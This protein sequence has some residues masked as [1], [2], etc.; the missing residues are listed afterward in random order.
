MGGRAHNPDRAV[1][2]R[3]T[4]SP[5]Q[6]STHGHAYS[7]EAIRLVAHHL[8][9]AT[10]GH[11][12]LTGDLVDG[13]LPLR[14]TPPPARRPAGRR[15]L[16]WPR[17]RVMVSAMVT[18]HR[19]TAALALALGLALVAPMGADAAR[20][21]DPTPGASGVGD[22]FFPHGG[23]G[24]YDVASYQLDL[25]YQPD[26]KTLAGKERIS[27]TATQTL[28]S[29]NLD[30]RG[31]D[32]GAVWVNHQPAR[33][34]RDGTDGQELTVTPRK[35]LKKNQRFTVSLSYAG[36]PEVVTDAD[37]SKE[38]WVPTADGAF[39]VGEPQGSPAWFAVNDTPADKAIY[40][41]SMTVPEGLTA[42]GNGSLVSQR[43]RKG[44]TT[45]RWRTRNPMASYLATITLGRFEVTRSRTPDGLPVYVA[46]DPA[47]VAASAPVVAKIPDMVAFFEEQFGPYPFEI[48]GAIVDDAPEVGYALETQTKPVFDRAPDEATMAHEL[49]HQWFGDSVTLSTWP[50]IWLNEGFAT[51]AEWLWEQ[52]S[53]G[54]TT[55]DQFAALYKTPA[56]DEIWNP[57]PNA[58]AASEQLFSTPVY[59][60]GAM[61]LEALRVK[62]GDKNFSRLLRSWYADNRNGN[63]TTA[64]F[65]ALA[66]KVSGQ[67]LGA[68]FTVWLTTPAKPATW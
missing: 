15:W 11:H 60:R 6:P 20:P 9:D 65:T 38:G 51:Y 25:S 37:G 48:V 67:D 58:L 55:A 43:T 8:V 13:G 62:I 16:T 24:G 56:T 68:F 19:T 27:A 34:S 33:F 66:A 3:L 41:V 17:V 10:L 2:A 28:S 49:A 4:L 61:T 29:F 52:H 30:L 32:V 18:R 50:D 39:V 54:A 5:L 1:W 12:R 14:T 22:P 46:V 21:A 36:T 26:T 40:D 59:N 23:N 7:A 57:A 44:E 64:D 63:V 42:V 47:L 31:M 35:S 53:G 45:F